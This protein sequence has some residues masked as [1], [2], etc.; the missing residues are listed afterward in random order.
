M[1][2]KLIRGGVALG[3]LGAMFA[4]KMPAQEL[5]SGKEWR[6]TRLLLSP[7]CQVPCDRNLDPQCDCLR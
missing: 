5:E 7:S 4:A 6:W 2:K 3:M 1:L